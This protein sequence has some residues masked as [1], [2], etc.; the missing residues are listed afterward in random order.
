MAELNKWCSAIIVL[1]EFK[2]VS[3]E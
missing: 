2:L 1:H 3:N